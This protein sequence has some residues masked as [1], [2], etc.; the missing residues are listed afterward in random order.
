MFLVS[1]VFAAFVAN[2]SI[3]LASAQALTDLPETSTP[4]KGVE[5][6]ADTK[7][8]KVLKKTDVQKEGLALWKKVEALGAIRCHQLLNL[9]LNSNAAKRAF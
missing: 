7:A 5:L 1:I 3:T 6:C 4:E 2:A 8:Y 9:K